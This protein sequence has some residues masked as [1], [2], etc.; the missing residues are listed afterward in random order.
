VEHCDYSVVDEE[1]IGCTIAYYASNYC[2][3]VAMVKKGGCQRHVFTIDIGSG[4][5]R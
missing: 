5:V 4:A 3:D 1:I 2:S